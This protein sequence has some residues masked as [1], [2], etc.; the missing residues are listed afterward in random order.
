MNSLKFSEILRRNKKLE[1]SFQQNSYNISL[2]SNV[3]V[4]QAKDVIEYSLRKRG[5]NANIELGDYDNIVQESQKNKKTDATIIFWE[6]SNLV[7]S[8]QY[9]IELLTK[10]EI[11]K[12]EDKIKLEIDFTISNLKSCP[13]VLVNKFSSLFF[14][15]FSISN[16][17]LDC[18]VYELNNYLEEITRPN[19]RLINLDKII[20]TVGIDNSLDSRY[21]YS[22]KAPYTVVFFKSYAEF[23][24][25]FFM[26]VNG[27]AKKALIFDCDN[28]LWGGVLG[29][30][31]IEISASTKY[32]AIFQDIQSIALSLSRQGVIIGL[33]SKNNPDDVDKVLANHA[34]MILRDDDISIKMVNW[35]DKVENLK[36]I[37]KDLN[38]GLDS[39][40]FVDD[41][42]FEVNLV[43]EQLPD[44]TVLQVPKKLYNYPE[45]ISSNLGLFYNISST[46]EDGDRVKSYRDEERRGIVKSKFSSMDEYLSSLDLEVI[47]FENSKSLISRIAQIT[48]KTNQFNLTTKRYTEIEI[49]NMVS[50][51]ATNVYAFSVRDKFGD[52]GVAGVC[53]VNFENNTA[54]IDSFLMSCRV[55]GRNIEYIFMDYIISS[56]VDKNIVNVTSV[57]IKTIKNIQ[58]KKFFDKCSF[59]VINV[60]GLNVHYSL[61]IDKYK[62]SG[63]KYIKVVDYD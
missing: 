8:F 27:K 24:K 44:V 31:D 15:C 9:K 6:I 11:N 10:D 17:K 47:F 48:Q 54:I 19:L 42:P 60:E 59:N 45:M 14:S 35:S 3:I 23:I 51:L 4:H 7:S 55:I 62:Q 30:D 29:E 49:E 46:V 33:C 58:V 32:G 38:I 22:S 56:L 1:C 63:I 40:V 12:I 16:K 21:Y 18:L 43:K 57:F 53:I 36:K 50:S 41:S 61:S 2:L 39:L 26:S 5:V 13:L 34:D 37:S 52:S 20:A 25:P 28:T